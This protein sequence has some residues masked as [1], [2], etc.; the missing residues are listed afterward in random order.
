MP[1][2]AP[3]STLPHRCSTVLLSFAVKSSVPLTT[4]IISMMPS[5]LS[6]R[7]SRTF[8]NAGEP[9]RSSKSASISRLFSC[10]SFL[11]LM[12]PG[13]S[14]AGAPIDLIIPGPKTSPASSKAPPRTPE[15]VEIG[16]IVS[17]CQ[18]FS[19]MPSGT[20]TPPVKTPSIP[21]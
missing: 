16:S 4:L 15:A 7:S 2:S 13:V 14:R 20:S 3:S 21:A 9:R 10:N 12:V 11:A 5:T 8:C 19:L 6:V 18:V 1:I 17:S